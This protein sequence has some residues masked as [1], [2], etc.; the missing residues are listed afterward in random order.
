MAVAFHPE[1]DPLGAGYVGMLQK[2][3][4]ENAKMI[5]KAETEAISNEESIINVE[6]N[7]TFIYLLGKAGILVAGALALTVIG[8]SVKLILDA[9]KV[10]EEYGKYIIIGLGSIYILQSVATILMNLNLG[11]QMN[12]NLPFVSYG[13]V[14]LVINLASIALIASIY[15]RK[16]ILAYEETKEN[17]R[18]TILKIGDA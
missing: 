1:T 13:G 9:T 12:I 7:Y 3:I 16:D 8:T 4:L 10:K 6:S 2:D 5:G 14:Y 15:R 17:K 11:I 18:F